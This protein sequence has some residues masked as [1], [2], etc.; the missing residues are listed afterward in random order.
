MNR[1]PEKKRYAQ[2]MQAL[3]KRQILHQLQMSK[4]ALALMIREDDW[5]GKSEGL[6]GENGRYSCHK[7][8]QAFQDSAERLCPRP[9]EG[10]AEFCYRYGEDLLFP[11]PEFSKSRKTYG[12]GALLLLAVLQ[13]LLREEREEAVF[14]WRLDFSF[15]SEEEAAQGECAREYA[16]LMERFQEEFVYEI[17][18][19]GG[20]VTPYQ[21][22]SHIGGV[23]YV[24]MHMARA[25]LRKGVKVDLALISGAA[26]IHDIGKLGCKPGERVPYLHYY[27]TDHWCKNRELK[28][29]GHIAANHSTWDLEV[30]NLQV[31][32]LL[33]IY[34][35]F[36]VKQ[37][38][39]K[40]GKEI[41]QIFTLSESFDVILKKLDN[42]DQAKRQRYEFVYTKLH[43]FQ[44]YMESLGVDI[45]L[46]GKPVKAREKR[47]IALQSPSQ[48]VETLKLLGVEHNIEVMHRLSSEKTFANILEAARS[49]KK[50][51]NIR[52]YINVFEEYFT[53]L[54]SRQKIQTL[55]FL[56]E[57]L[58]HHQ[59]DIRRQAAGLM[60]NIIAHFNEGYK[61][62]LPADALPESDDDTALH[63]W[64][65]YLDMMIFPD[66]KLTGQH[67][68]WI[69]Y[70]LKVVISSVMEHCA[71]HDR[72]LYLDV[73][74]SYY[75]HPEKMKEATA[76]VL[77][78]AAAD[79][80]LVL[81]DSSQLELLRGLCLQSA[82]SERI[83]LKA[84]SLRAMTHMA[85]SL[86]GGQT[87]DL[88][89]F[90]R[91]FDPGKQPCLIFLKAGLWEALFPETEEIRQMRRSLDR[92]DIVSEIFL[93]NLKTAT[94]WIVKSVNIQILLDQIQR[95]QKEHLL[96]IATHFS[97]LIKVSERVVVRHDAGAGL[98]QIGPYLTLDQRNEIAVELT[99]GL[100]V[101]E[102]EF[103]KYIPQYLGVFA[104]WL[105]PKE[106]DELIGRLEELL[107]SSSDQIVSVSLGTVGYLL[108]NYASYGKRFSLDRESCE[109]R[110]D[111]LLGMLLK[112]LASYR[113]TV[114]QEALLVF[115]QGLFASPVLTPEEKADIFKR[116]FKKALFLIC[117]H[118]KGGLSF[119]YRAAALNHIYR[120]LTDQM[121]R[122][123]GFRFSHRS[124]IAFFPGTFDP[125]TL[126]H[127]GIAQAIRD[128]GFEVMLAVDEFSWSKK[129]QP[130]LIRRQ[131]VSMSVADEFHIHLFPDAVSINLA[132]P[133][134]LKKLRA[135]FPED[136]VYV[137]VGSDVVANAS[138]YR[139]PDTPYSIHHFNHIVFWRAGSLEEEVEL[140]EEALSRIDGKVI[141]LSL[142]VH[143]ED[144]SSTRIRENIDLNRD[145]SNL[146]D[147]SA[148]EFI[149]QNSLYLR[150]PQY[151]QV[152]LS[153]DI[154]FE[155]IEKPNAV[156]LD[157]LFGAVLSRDQDDYR[158]SRSVLEQGDSLVVMKTETGGDK[159]AGFATFRK[160][161]Y[162]DLL[163][164]LKDYELVEK[165]RGQV[166]GRLL[167]I[168][169]IYVA[170][171]KQIE[172]GAQLLLT[173]AL[174]EG[175][176]SDCTYG[177]FYSQ[178][179]QAL[180][181]ET[182]DALLRQGFVRIQSR[183]H[184]LYLVN[185]QAPVVL[186]QNLETTFKE[187][188]ASD[189]QILEVIGKAHRRLQRVMT[190]LYPGNLVL[191]LSA[192]I[193][194]RRLIEK[195]T[196]LNGVPLTPLFPRKLGPYMCV[197]FGKILRNKAVPNT[198]TKTLHTDKVF[199]PDIRSF[200]IEAYPYYSP[201]A[202][203]IRTIH[204]FMRPVILVDDLLHAG[205]RIQALKP[206]LEK[207]AIQVERILVGLLSGKGRDLMRLQQLP[208]DCIYY[209][210]NMKKWF[211]ESSLYP[212]IGGDTV[213]REK[214]P[215]A[216]LMPSVNLILPYAS[217]EFLRPCS[218]EGIFDLS[219]VCIENARDIFLALE[220]RYRTIFGRNLTL[221]RLSE[222]VILPQC[223]DKGSCMNYDAGVAASV[224]L[225][226]DIEMLLRVRRRSEEE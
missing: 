86:E 143:L 82:L 113:E 216:G 16:L 117:E 84:A 23:H 214:A 47:D 51:K 213:R 89:A 25:L 192:G 191:S 205:A 105:H 130:K 211:V 77:L 165:I 203:Q 112:G 132:N 66:H 76:F 32:S 159:T 123:G 34:A 129:T 127:K 136:E 58:M 31:E 169:G 153:K 190:K 148:Q 178:D 120:F 139:A 27:Y 116:C 7:V 183:E 125:F 10:W 173:E 224:Y 43:D 147:P 75:Q 62:E 95:G 193:I 96:H 70:T 90:V 124:R 61:K 121:I 167:L 28:S 194:H 137:V 150:E 69:G 103:S 79:L 109:K 93:D 164:Q 57:L 111:R 198:V 102:Y 80:P 55:D 151:K 189:P 149:Y 83:D 48:A 99:K 15:C 156:M 33:L 20:E 225:E 44:D 196:D 172:D 154:V 201:L 12:P 219:L 78:D 18:R 8:I 14:D 180:G 163:G 222:A 177:L 128:M 115:G 142:P 110:Q 67:K 175:L 134:D 29:I 181:E 17:L 4:K 91:Q 26:L 68:S 5:Q 6:L 199:Q 182:E 41:S 88:R 108:Q 2:F 160:T 92:G 171:C 64:Q 21:T 24:A 168:S 74:F 100:E 141:E 36:R 38:F 200:S 104:L 71:F 186:I 140:S 207:E 202:N 212:F 215:V 155:W 85:K 19:L 135:M 146:I 39:D 49:E 3:G 53:Y 188:F 11:D 221:G 174:A 37:S 81:C 56:Y 45:S 133:E 131:I 179:Y 13:T 152:L 40:N 46:S 59:G 101:G 217:P 184:T 22:L 170:G 42:V 162:S 210:P 208:V 144:I 30:E 157:R 118:Q 94:P 145:I 73:L 204:S 35:D 1:K 166:S 218:Q 52:A 226:N 197:P 87:E 72:K 50:W 138:A 126:S 107:S 98:L 220:A 9:P 122:R 119:F 223:P 176:T 187:P 185:L 206:L 195:I 60:G 106:L 161:G 97:N 158:L 63:M 54:N 65:T 209:I 114:R